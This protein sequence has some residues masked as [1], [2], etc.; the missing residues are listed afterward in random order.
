MIPPPKLQILDSSPP[1]LQDA[2]FDFEYLTPSGTLEVL[3]A[4]P[5]LVGTNATSI[6]VLKEGMCTEL[7]QT[8]YYCHLIPTDT[9]A[10]YIHTTHIL[11][12]QPPS[13]EDWNKVAALLLDR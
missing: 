5:L 2:I 13:I 10:Y 7:T 9:Y 3:N 6:P 11:N 12:R 4:V 1:A 8:P